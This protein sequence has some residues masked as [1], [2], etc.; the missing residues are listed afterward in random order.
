[1]I[2]ED[3]HNIL[4]S[5]INGGCLSKTDILASIISK[6]A[7]FYRNGE[8]VV[9]AYHNLSSQPATKKT[10]KIEIS[11]SMYQGKNPY[12]IRMMDYLNQHLKNDLVGAYLHGSLGTYDENAFSDFDGLAILR[13]GVFEKPDILAEAALKL[14]EARNIMLDFDP[15]QHHGW[16]VLTEGDLQYYPEHY[17]PWELFQYA[18]SLLREKGL[19]F[20]I[21]IR[22]NENSFKRGFSELSANI[23]RRIERKEY[24]KNVYQLKSFLSQFLLLPSLYI[25]ACHGKGIYKKFSFEAAKLD[26]AINDWAIMDEISILR[27][28][29]SYDLG[30]TRKRLMSRPT[31][32]S[33]Y[34]VKHLGPPIPDDIRYL[35]TTDFYGRVKKLARLM[36][37]KIR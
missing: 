34:L 32:I 13:N 10:Q 27:E 26:F 33:H 3:F 9:A 23:I 5:Y 16:F 1:M 31:V 11:V 29:W 25:Q 8:I 17:F 19:Q 22:S 35:L 12:V 6:K 37:T 20:L 2:Y 15:I 21:Q 28:K 14:N 4:S 7:P 36:Q 24:P 18:K 30:R